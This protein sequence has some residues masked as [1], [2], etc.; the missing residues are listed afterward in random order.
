[1]SLSHR[2]VFVHMTTML[3]F[4]LLNAQGPEASLRREFSTPPNSARPW[5]Y[6]YF[7]EGNL[8]KQGMTADL[9]AMKR[10]GIGGGI[11]LEVNIG[12]PKGPVRYM[13]PEWLSSV[14][15]AVKEADRLG[16]E[17]S[18]GTGPGWC[19]T[20]GPWVPPDQAMQHLVSAQTKV[21]GP[22]KYQGMLA[23]PKP[24]TPFFGIGSLNPEL[25]KQWQEFYRD[26][27]V[28][29]IPTPAKETSISDLD[30]KALVYRAPYSSVPGVKPYL[31]AGKD[32]VGKDALVSSTGNID[33]TSKMQPDG[34]LEW[35]VPA[36]DWTI[37]RFGR[38]L[39]G[40]T[41]RP[42]PDAGL[43]FET[44]KFETI[45]ID[46]HLKT[47]VDAILK[48]TGPNKTAGQGL[49][50][51]HFDSWEMGSQNWSA[52][53][54]K[55]FQQQRGYDPTPYM[56]VL[57]GKIV[58]SVD[59]SE[60]FLW[61]LR[62]TA[63]E[64]IIRNHMGPIKQKAKQ[65]G[66]S[67]TVEP[68]DLN[69][70]SDVELGAT[71]DI[72]SGEFWS[73]GYGYPCEYSCFEA[74]SV[75][76][77]NGKPVVAAES[78][79]S[80]DR[81]GWIQHPASMKEQGDWALAAGINK[82]VFHRYQHQ[83]NSDALP[84]MT[85]GPYGVHWERTQTWWDMASGYHSYISRSQH[86]LRQGLPVV[87]VLYLVP[88]GAPNVFQAPPSASVG[89]LPDRRGYGFD[90]CAP[91]TLIS[92]ATVK[93]GQ[94]V[95]P[96]GMSYRLLVLPRVGTMTPKLARKI[97]SLVE[98]GATVIGNPPHTS[99]SLVDFPKA[100]H[101]VSQIGNTIWND[102][103][104]NVF[105]DTEV[106]QIPATLHDAHW[107]WTQEP[108]AA[109]SA[110]VGRRNF[111]KFFSIPTGSP[112]ASA[113]MAITADNE[114]AAT[115]DGKKI[116]SGT[117][118]NQVREVDISRF[119]HVG[120]NKLFVEVDNVG[121][122]P[123]PAGM[124]ASV[125]VR[126]KDGSSMTINTDETWNAG[127]KGAAAVSLGTWTMAPW[128]LRD[129]AMPRPPFYPSY[130][131]TSKIL[132]ETLRLVPD[133]DSGDALRYSH[134]KIGNLDAYF[135]GNRSKD[136]FTGKVG[137]RVTQGAPEWWNP[138]TGERRSLPNFTRT[139]NQTFIPISLSGFESGFVVFSTA[140]S[141]PNLNRVNF[142]RLKPV[143]TLTGPWS[144]TFDSRFDDPK[145]TRFD[146]LIDWTKRPE[147][148]V[149]HYSGKATYQQ[150]FD[151]PKL[152]KQ[153]SV[154]SL[155]DVKNIASVRLNGKELGIVWCSPWQVKIPSGVLKAK[156]NRLEIMV[157][158]LW[159]NRLIGDASLPAN[160]RFTKTTFSPFNAQ[161]AL[162]PSGLL[163]PV[164][165]LR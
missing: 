26:E 149:Q 20:G 40:Q 66:L 130:E 69:P 119:V 74:V 4:A 1:M 81:D 56:P 78:F 16:L 42:A 48:E 38:T 137:F 108:K 62:Q 36:G 7:M 125:V 86:M 134:R 165:I 110:P 98:A 129:T 127:T 84:G 111:T 92:R 44:D 27:V 70:A 145:P 156:G 116:A 106:T 71:A 17:I 18:L 91:S 87:D 77:T 154:L 6:W 161:S 120:E 96:D 148:D 28:L 5:V 29:A 85:M 41:T 102:K 10:A 138:I 68:Y 90:A 49:V 132:R 133:L 153:E 114:F 54:R 9:E 88:E 51:L 79:T 97:Q 122:S 37:L 50:G 100:D 143:T 35:D 112:I 13:S 53:F 2:V 67:L 135:V 43:G 123:N 128:N 73:K 24:R 32:E 63:Q 22:K 99:P 104:K 52:N 140:V 117:D 142:P 8:D 45:G 33:L 12:I 150:M 15:H 11:F 39:T 152:S 21:T 34:T 57:A 136:Q 151:A 25:Q 141:K 47:F 109:A 3:L 31:F 46:A 126:F 162:Q 131:T 83:P 55:L 80:D 30:E 115:I 95:F 157:A 61:D 159:A 101:E 113:R 65:N 19:G 72:P 124:I 139:K 121:T 147:P 158:N 107:I 160:Q 76:H 163:G 89:D 146:Q 82:F 60:R 93:N 14:G 118:F 103:R 144:V 155:G 75:A 94:V 23:Q 58:D 164:K 64:L 105:R 59:V